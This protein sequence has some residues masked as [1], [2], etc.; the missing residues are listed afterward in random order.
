MG[1]EV[2]DGSHT[3]F[4]FVCLYDPALLAYVD[5]DKTERGRKEKLS[6]TSTY[7]ILWNMKTT[8]NNL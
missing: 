8:L 4:P 1:S 3:C 6:F 2:L 5:T 7:Q